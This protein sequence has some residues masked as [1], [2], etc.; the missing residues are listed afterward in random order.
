MKIKL[1]L[2]LLLLF[3]CFNIIGCNNN[4]EQSKITEKPGYDSPEITHREQDK[5][6]IDD[7][8]LAETQEEADQDRNHPPVIKS[9][10]IESTSDPDNGKQFVAVV[11]ATDPDNDVITFDYEW[12]VDGEEIPGATGETL[13][14]GENMKKGSTVSVA[15]IPFDGKD[16]GVWKG[17]GSFTIPNSPPIITSEPSPRVENG[18]LT[19]LLEAEDPD[20]DPIEYTLRSAPKGM[21]I[22]PATGLISWEFGQEDL[23][24][25]KVE[26]IVTD[27]EG[28]KTSQTLSLNI[29][30]QGK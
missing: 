12:R 30:R 13:E 27:S 7:D 11:D 15:A 9:I 16:Q 22:E 20:G 4:G 17:E 18:K 24:E 28:A 14:W 5:D 26:I 2:S 29:A 21:T 23:G 25:H 10:S 8:T 6:I 3:L 1:I 19:Y